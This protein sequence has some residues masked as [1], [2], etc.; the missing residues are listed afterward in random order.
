MRHTREIIFHFKTAAKTTDD[1][2]ANERRQKMRERMESATRR[3]TNA[4]HKMLLKQ[5]NAERDKIVAEAAAAATASPP[6]VNGCDKNTERVLIA[7]LVDGINCMRLFYL[8]FLNAEKIPT[9]F[10]RHSDACGWNLCDARYKLNKIDV[11]CKSVIIVS[12][13]AVEQPPVPPRHTM[14]IEKYTLASPPCQRFM[15]QTSI[16]L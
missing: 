16:I 2:K 10:R 7:V 5:Q 13:S 9:R 1:D 14:P 3:T 4:R 6:M 12:V 8:Q 15:Y 11:P